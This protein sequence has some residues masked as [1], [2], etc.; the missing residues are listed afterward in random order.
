MCKHSECIPFTKKKHSLIYNI[1][2]YS[3]ALTRN[4]IIIWRSETK[5]FYHPNSVSCRT[6]KFQSFQDL[7]FNFCPFIETQINNI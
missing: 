3:F 5:F 1:L 4:D 2:A 6:D 7:T